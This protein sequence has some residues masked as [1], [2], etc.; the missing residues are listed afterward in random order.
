MCFLSVPFLVVP[1]PSH[2]NNRPHP[3]TIV[4]NTATHW[5]TACRNRQCT[6]YTHAHTARRDILHALF[7]YPC[8]CV[9]GVGSTSSGVRIGCLC[10]ARAARRGSKIPE[11]NT[12]HATHAFRV[13]H[14]EREEE[15][16]RREKEK[17]ERKGDNT[18]KIPSNRD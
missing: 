18:N 1:F 2:A 4:T 3:M 9:Y 15:R 12:D 17:Q 16:K 13:E 10:I 8:V 6:V 7:A 11:S 5:S 14:T